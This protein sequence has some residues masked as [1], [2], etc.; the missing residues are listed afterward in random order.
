MFDIAEVE[1]AARA[2]FRPLPAS[3]SDP[4]A[5][6]EAALQGLDRRVAELERHVAELRRAYWRK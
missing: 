3:A 2:I 4:F 6:P 1:H 5:E